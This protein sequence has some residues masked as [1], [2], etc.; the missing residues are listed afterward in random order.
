[1]IQTAKIRKYIHIEIM[2]I[3]NWCH[4][5]NLPLLLT[6]LLSELVKPLNEM[7]LTVKEALEEAEKEKERQRK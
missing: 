7:G 5:N 4:N 1:M 2:L 6:K 3:L